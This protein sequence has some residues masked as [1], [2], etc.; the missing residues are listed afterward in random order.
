MPYHEWWESLS[1]E[2]I[3][4]QTFIKRRWD[5]YFYKPS[6]LN[7]MK[8]PTVGRIVLYT[9]NWHDAEA[10]NFYKD[11]ENHNQP[12]PE[13]PA[14]ITQVWSDTCV[15]LQVITDGNG[16]HWRTSMNLSAGKNEYGGHPAYSW[17]WPE[18]PMEEKYIMGMDPASAKE[19]KKS[20]PEERPNMA[21]GDG[22]G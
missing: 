8:K 20:D 17:H 3:N 18:L 9:P 12:L 15:N 1:S 21:P 4:S 22:L 14:I 2:F 10:Y 19:I 11:P 13:V 5:G 6:N 7:P 16:I